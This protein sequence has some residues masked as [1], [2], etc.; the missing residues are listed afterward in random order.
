MNSIKLP[1]GAELKITMSPFTEGRSLYQA[2]LEEAKSL[3]LA[4][5]TEIDVNFFKDIFCSALSSKKIESCIWKCMERSTYNDLKITIDTFEPEESR[6]DYFDVMM[7]V[8]RYNVLPF[9][10]NLSAKY[11]QVLGLLKGNQA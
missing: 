6:Q 7:E 1:S 2:M 9:T 8:A 3:S 5:N 11:S 10:K 4:P